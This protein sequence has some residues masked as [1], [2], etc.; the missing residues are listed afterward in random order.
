[1]EDYANRG[2]FRG[3][4]RQTIRSGVAAFKLTWF[5]DRVFDLI[6]DTRKKTIKIPLVLPR[7]PDSIYADFKAFVRSHQEPDLPDH[8]RVDKAKARLR[9]SNRRGSVSVTVTVRDGDYDYA[10]RRLIHLIHETF[11]IF[12]LDGRYSDYVIEQLGADPDW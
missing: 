2:V 11:V 5:R 9:C 3:F 8:R 1:M 10:L 4:S 6:A 12:L 7:L